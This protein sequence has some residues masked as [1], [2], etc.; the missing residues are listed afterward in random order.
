MRFSA[1]DYKEAVDDYE[2]ALKLDPDLLRANIGLAATLSDGVVFG[3]SAD[4]RGNML[5]AEKLADEALVAE[6]GN[7]IAHL[8]KALVYQSLIITKLRTSPQPQGEAGIAE[9]DTAIGLDQNLATAHA[10]SGYWRLFLRRAGEGFSGLETAMTLSP[11]D[12]VRPIWEFQICHL[13]S[14]LAQWEQ[15]IEHCRLAAQ[16]PPWLWFIYADIIASNARLRRDA[17]AKAALADLLKRKPDMTAQAY[18]A[19]AATYSDNA[20]FTEQIAHGR[21]HAQGRTAG[22][23]SQDE[24]IFCRPPSCKFGHSFYICSHGHV[25]YMWITRRP[26][27]TEADA[28]FPL[29]G[30]KPL[31]KTDPGKSIEIL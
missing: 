17:E 22:G 30:D 29:F 28:F 18:V 4:P 3:W 16:G 24:L 12:P 5:R 2:R 26:R 20:V 14:H 21:G 10:I 13:H 9:A 6:S 8:V 27:C 25:G 15:A 1:A 23:R 31:T 19:A 7:A 11:H